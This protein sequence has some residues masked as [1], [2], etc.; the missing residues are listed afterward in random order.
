MTSAFFG[1]ASRELQVQ[2][3]GK[4]TSILHALTSILH[5]LTSILHIK[6]SIALQHNVHF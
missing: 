1:K 6:Y 5:V 3:D 4:Y 2:M